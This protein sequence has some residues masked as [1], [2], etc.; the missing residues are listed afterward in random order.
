[1]TGYVSGTG[2]A[3]VAATDTILGALQKING[4]VTSLA[5]SVSLGG[6]IPHMSFAANDS[7]FYVSGG[8][9][10]SKT[11]TVLSN[12]SLNGND[13]KTLNIGNGGVLNTAA[14]DPETQFATALQGTHADS[15]MQA[16]D[17]TDDKITGKLL[18]GFTTATSGG[19]LTGT[20][21]ILVALEKLDYSYRVFASGTTNGVTLS[22]SD[23]GFSISGGNTTS[24][25]LKVDTSLEFAG[26]DG[27]E[28]IFPTLKTGQASGT[29][30]LTSDASGGLAEGDV[31]TYD[32]DTK[33][34]KCSTSLASI[35]AIALL[36]SSPGYT[37][38]Q[39]SAHQSS[40]SG[41]E[42][43]GTNSD[44]LTLLQGCAVN[45]VLM[46]DGG[47]WMCSIN[48]MDAKAVIQIGSYSP[49]NPDAD[50]YGYLDYLNVGSVNF[51]SSDQPH[52][53]ALLQENGYVQTTIDYGN[54]G[55]TRRTVS[56]T[57][58]DNSIVQPWTF[59]NGL[60]VLGSG[61]SN[62]HVGIFN[63]A[64]ITGNSDMTYTFPAV[65]GNAGNVA[66]TNPNN[67]TTTMVKGDLCSYDSDTKL[68]SCATDPT[69]TGTGY[70]AGS[71]LSSNLVAPTTFDLGGKLTGNAVFTES[72]VLGVGIAANFDLSG[73]TGQLKTGSGGLAVTGDA[74]FNGNATIASGELT[75]PTILGGTAT[76]SGI[77]LQST[78]FTNPTGDFISFLTGS[79]AGIERM[80]I[81]NAGY[82]GIGVPSPGAFLSIAKP[83]VSAQ[84]NLAAPVTAGTDPSGTRVNGDLWYNGTNLYFDKNGTPEDLL[85]GGT[86]G[87]QWGNGT[88]LNNNNI[89]FAGGKVGIGPAFTI[90][91]IPGAQT[92]IRATTEQLRLSY[93]AS[94]YTSFTVGSAGGLSLNNGIS[95]GG[96]LG[97]TGTSS[98]TGTAG[99]AALTSSGITTPTILGGTATTSG[100]TLQSTNFTNPTGDFISFLTGSAAGIER[101]RITNAGYVGIGTTSAPLGILDVRGGTSTTGSGTD[102]NFY[103]QNGLTTGAGPYNGGNI[104]LNPGA[105]GSAGNAGAIAL[106]GITNIAGNTTIATGKSLT[107]TSGTG[108]LTQ[109][110]TNILAG[111]G[112]VYNV[113]NNNVGSTSTTSVA[114]NGVAFNLSNITNTSSTYTDTIN[115]ISFESATNNNSNKINGINFASATGFNNFINTPTFTLAANGAITSPTHFGGSAAGSSLTLQSTSATSG[116]AADY[117]AFVTGT[118]S[119]TE[120]MRILTNG[121]VGIGT[122]VPTGTLSVNP[123]QYSSGGSTATLAGST[124]TA[125][126]NVFTNT[127][128]GSQL[129]FANGQSAGTILTNSGTSVTVS[130]PNSL[131]IGTQ[132]AFTVNYTGL[133]VASIASGAYAGNVG[134]GTTA[135]SSMLTVAGDISLSGSL[136]SGTSRVLNVSTRTNDIFLG[137]QNLGAGNINITSTANNNAGV[138][139]GALIALTSGASNSAFGTSSLSNLQD[140][141]KNIAVGELAL[142]QLTT[143]VGNVA[144]GE[145][146]LQNTNNGSGNTVDKNTAVGYQALLY[147]TIG[148]G[149]VA[150]GANAGEG[151]N[152]NLAGSNNTFIGNN[153]GNYDGIIAT[154]NGLTNATA[155]GYNAQVT[156]SNSLILGGVGSYKVNVGIGTTSPGGTLDVGAAIAAAG[157]ATNYVTKI[158][159]TLSGAINS[160]QTAMY[161]SYSLPT[162]NLSGG[163]SN[164]LTNLYNEYDG[165]TATAGTVTNY[166]GN[167]IAAPT[168]SGTI[169]NKYAMVTEANAGNVGIGTTAPGSTLT[170]AGTV[171]A[172]G[173][174]INLNVSSNFATNINTGTS[175]G[176]VTIGG[177]AGNVINIG[178]DDT[179]ADT[180]GIGSSKDALTIHSAGFNVSTASQLT[181][182]GLQAGTGWQTTFQTQAQSANI[183][184]KLPASGPTANGQVLTISDYTTGTLAWNANVAAASGTQGGVQ[185]NW[186]GSNAM[187]DDTNNFYYDKTKH[188][189][190]LG[191]NSATPNLTAMLQLYGAS[192]G[193]EFSADANNNATLASNGNGE[194]T[195]N[196]KT[197]GAV[198]LDSSLVIGSGPNANLTNNSI[199]TM[200]DGFDADFYQGYDYSAHQ[201]KIGTGATGLPPTTSTLTG[202]SAITI[203][204]GTTYPA[205]LVGIG[206]APSTTATTALNVTGNSY[207]SGTGYFTNGTQSISDARFKKNVTTI[208]GATALSD[209]MQLRGVTYDFN[210]DKWPDMNFST[211]NQIGFIAQDVEP[212]VPQ[213]VNTD[214]NGY[215]SIA[216]DK[217]TA[218]IVNAVQQ[219]QSE[220]VTLQNTTTQNTSDVAAANL[221]AQQQAASLADLSLKTDTNITTLTGLQTSVD[222]QLTT[223]G[224]SL[225]ANTKSISDQ[226]ASLTALDAR[227]TAIE[228]FDAQ[229][230]TLNTTLQAQIDQLKLLTDA[231]NQALN[232]A[233]IGLNTTDISFIKTLLG[234]DTSAPGDVKLSGMLTAKVVDGGALEI[235]VADETHRTIGTAAITAVK[236]DANNDG[237]DDNTGSNGKLVDVKNTNIDDKSKVFISFEGNP[238]SYSWVTKD[239]DSDGNYTGFT[240]NTKDPVS[241]DAN[242]DW[243]IVEEK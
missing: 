60:Q 147:N 106:N 210:T 196:T 232:I 11:L 51:N 168:G 241:A 207:V 204:M 52:D 4:N 36:T 125:S 3:T 25:T 16:A 5:S 56:Q 143:G 134:I 69:K 37:D 95:V 32:S 184:Y 182:L 30:A 98:F 156:A 1:M 64:Q 83:L 223:I 112:S 129:I 178:T 160:A 102:I 159:P 150:L 226:A 21:S 13:S 24:K 238:G 163:S 133:N 34:I 20:D 104:N 214:A 75:T 193:L 173:G 70:T 73:T 175:T 162:V 78:N 213:V 41:L 145:Q 103:A 206:G 158:D 174:I 28:F 39:K 188:D 228:T 77:T 81:T 61:T 222:E 199:Y 165:L 181:T 161:G 219:Q 185:F 177:T 122:T 31:C 189:L 113:T 123:L 127:M 229:Q 45:Q 100:I 12:I 38:V 231:D 203:G 18:T 235:E 187:S 94:D 242:V 197:S 6:G 190:G 46:W 142:T 82:V 200:Y 179:V 240:I 96:N 63:V 14:F 155:I 153:A 157:G 89:F 149:N 166:Y 54:S 215:K 117:I 211:A 198:P 171:A 137:S 27:S 97:V 92:E 114:I 101:M 84:I 87:S 66:I 169:T 233:Q 65:T 71:G 131:S 48:Y 49:T 93:D 227:A 124:V 99:F 119:Q 109:N 7:G 217:L 212:I 225:N 80:R 186:G 9:T 154:L 17:V 53:F 90:A 208:D 76:T 126:G 130:N 170:V 180:I 135:P 44:Q 15:A 33:S 68:I 88:L 110:Y 85:A 29:V 19:A 59:A 136:L 50:H 121:N 201:F 128:V 111:N 79:A 192:N 237:T 191:F 57:G 239:K 138:G 67:L 55:I 167:Y 116:T 151:N 146:A 118:T 105:A 91:T 74:T 115:G 224:T 72:S 62:A 35:S 58:T 148:T 140:G 132:T 26:G 194:L 243:W 218:I 120:K 176:A 8:V 43:D 216:Y 230:T 172:A 141:S 234:I 47:K 195:V 108:T 10:T 86:G 183:A 236:T 107:M 220:I 202:V 205:N 22:A 23:T 40:I 164:T 2:G 209:V 42:K 144:I 139:S 221:L 152:L